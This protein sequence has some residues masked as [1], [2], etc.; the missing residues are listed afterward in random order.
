MGVTVVTGAGG[1]LGRTVAELL[2]G[3]DEVHAFTHAQLDVSDDAAVDAAFRAAR[4]DLVVH[5]AAMT[6]VDACERE[7][8]KAWAV[9]AD[10]PRF[11]AAAA[12]EVGAEIVAVSTDYVFDGEKGS[13]VETD[14]PNPVQVYGRAKLAGEGRVREANPRHYVVRSAW[15]FGPSGHNFLSQL[16]RLVRE[17]DEVKVLGDQWSSPTYAPDLARAIADVSGT[18]RYGTY[19]VT[20]AG[21]CS[22]AEF[23]RHALEVLGSH[24]PVT[25]LT[26]SDIPRPARRPRNS[27]LVGEAWTAAGFAP[28]RPW[29]DAAT[30]FLT[31]GPKA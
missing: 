13:Y 10:G 17:S 5:C 29:R 9:N 28:L 12:A 20:N 15:I 2:Q 8:D 21:G 16:P 3:S 22:H 19:H 30:A 26:T 1:L 4:P 11:V 6:N 27:T 7:P 14:E 18:G 23:F 24:V 25:E 31:E